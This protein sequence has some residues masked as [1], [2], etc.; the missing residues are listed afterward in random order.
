MNTSLIGSFQLNNATTVYA[1]YWIVPMPALSSVSSGTGRFFRGS[2]RDD[3][4]EEGIRALAFGDEPDGS[5][6]IYDFA[7]RVV[8]LKG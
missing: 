8:P 5:R 1:I 4:K 6:T 3:L 2:S 7:V